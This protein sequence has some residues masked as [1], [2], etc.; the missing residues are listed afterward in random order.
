MTA[1]QE[2]AQEANRVA[3]AEEQTAPQK[4]IGDVVLNVENIDLSFGGVA[5]LIGVSFEIREHE[6]LAIIGP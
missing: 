5:A 1:A 2:A 3:G 6:I 4:A